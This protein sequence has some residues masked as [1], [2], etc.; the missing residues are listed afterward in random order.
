MGK[1]I[2]FNKIIFIRPGKFLAKR[3]S[4][5]YAPV[6]GA[7]DGVAIYTKKNR[8]T[9]VCDELVKVA[10]R[11]AHELTEKIPVPAVARKHLSRKDVAFIAAAYAIPLPGTALFAA[12][13]V[14]SKL[15][16][17]QLRLRLNPGFTI[18]ASN[19]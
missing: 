14:A 3:T 4:E 11:K 10:L 8:F 19:G 15:A 12:A 7:S 9:A 13:I 5:F 18:D 16:C 6:T 17:R 2:V 1:I